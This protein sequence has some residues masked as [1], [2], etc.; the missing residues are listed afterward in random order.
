MFV[1]DHIVLKYLNGDSGNTIKNHWIFSTIE[2]ENYLFENPDMKK[3]EDVSK[4]LTKIQDKLSNF[5]PLNKDIYSALYPDWLDI[6]KDMNILLVVGCPNP[7]DAMV[8]EHEGKLY[9]IFDLIRFSDYK[10]KGYD[11]DFVIKQLITHETSHLCLHKKYPVLNSNNFV[12][13]LKYIT[14]NEGFAHLLGFKDDV[15]KFDF[16]EIINK[17]YHISFLQL[18]EALAEK[19]T[20]KQV[21]WLRKSN[22]G[23]YW[24]KFAAIS[25]KLFL[26]NHIEEVQKIY[27]DGIDN[28]I[29]Y[30]GL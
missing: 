12:E 11:I 25:G 28:F 6:T 29:S 18:K 10:D 16:S 9:I 5:S 3:K 13:Q 20:Q 2:K 14:F 30:M 15:E 7:Y 21:D 26:A 8:R 27:N 22:S 1:D 24:G 4:I 17:Y 23:Q 19:D